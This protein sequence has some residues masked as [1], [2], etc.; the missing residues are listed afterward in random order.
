MHENGRFSFQTSLHVELYL[1]ILCT[2]NF[3]M[4]SDISFKYELLPK[5]ITTFHEVDFGK[6]FLV[7]RLYLKILNDN[8]IAMYKKETIMY[9]RFSVF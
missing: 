3:S 7:E 4:F 5:K 8:K 2:M 6:H 9:L 1:Q